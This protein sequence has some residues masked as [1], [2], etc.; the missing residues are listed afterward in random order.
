MG[1]CSIR[2]SGRQYLAQHQGCLRRFCVWV[3]MGAGLYQVSV[4][5]LSSCPPGQGAGWGSGRKRL[6]AGPWNPSPPPPL[7]CI[8]PAASPTAP[9][10]GPQ[11]LFSSRANSRPFSPSPPGAECLD[12]DPSLPPPKGMAHPPLHESFLLNDP[13]TKA[14]KPGVGAGPVCWVKPSAIPSCGRAAQ[15]C[16]P[17]S[18]QGGR[19]AQLEARAQPRWT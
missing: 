1:F 9:G 2:A 18:C 11:C 17:Q 8:W 16:R 12:H 6:I 3:V 4:S 5:L 13:E 10:Q 19:G 15:A 14:G 7:L